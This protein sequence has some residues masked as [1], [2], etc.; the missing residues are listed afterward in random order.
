MEEEGP[1]EA[2]SGKV[3]IRKNKKRNTE[4]TDIKIHISYN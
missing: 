2:V 4:I 1:S 3:S